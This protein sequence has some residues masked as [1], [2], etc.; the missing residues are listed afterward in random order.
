MPNA[1]IG[2]LRVVLGMNAGEFRR[3]S[4]S[5][6]GEL[7]TLGQ[8]FS[9]I[10]SKIDRASIFVNTGILA[11]RRFANVSK[12][13][14]N[15]ASAFEQ[16]MGNVG[17]L[18]NTNT[19]NL[20][21][22]SEAVLAI[23]R[24]TP[25]S[26]NELTS[27]LYDVR[28]AGIPAADALS[29]L[30]GSAQL[31]VAGLGT[32]KEAVDLVTSSI[33]AFGLRGEDA[34]RVYDQIFKT[35][36]A[37]KT[38][39][40]QLAQGFGAVAGTVAT[41]GIKLDDYLSSVAALTTTGLPA[42]QAHTQIRA[43]IAG[44]LRET[45]ET[46]A[47]FDALGVKTFKQLVEQSGSVVVAFERIVRATRG[48][49]AQMIKL[50]GSVEAY[51]AVIGLAGKQNEAYQS[52]L[53][54]MRDG[55]N[56]VSE[57]FDKQDS[58]VSSTT[59]RLTNNIQALG[60]AMG[61][62]LAPAIKSISD[63]VE[64]LTTTFK[65][66]SPEMQEIIAKTGVF[67]AVV[68]PAVIAIGFFG[69]ALASLLPVFAAVGG[70]VAGL[71]A[72]TGPIGMFII[73]ASLATTAWFTFKDEIISIWESIS[74][75]VSD[76]IDSITAK[77]QQFALSISKAF[78]LITEGEFTA[79][80]QQLGNTFVTT[81]DQVNRAAKS[82][83]LAAQEWKAAAE[84][85]LPAAAA[86]FN[87]GFVLPV[88]EGLSE[89]EKLW[90][91]HNEAAR[92]FGL[93]TIADI[94]SPIEEMIAQQQRLKEALDAG[95]LSAGQFGAAMQKATFVAL[96]AYAGMASGI[97]NNLAMAFGESKA[98]AIAAAVINTAESI[99]KTLATYGATPWGLAAAAAAA[100]AGAAQ[101]ATIRSANK[102]GGGGG[103]SA[104]TSTAAASAGPT[105]IPQS[106]TVNL[107]GD[108]FGREQVFNLINSIN[109][110][111][112]DGAKIRIAA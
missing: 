92:R 45:K 13:I 10:S 1:V 18:I 85:T 70:L 109:D 83:N 59:Q 94:R 111:V 16:G 15:V 44:L 56:A 9:D 76:K 58:T 32:T 75:F 67:V 81:G 102:G 21:A 27:A 99:T 63:F 62:A 41:A 31:A 107:H 74:T 20:N 91:R 39:I 11:A 87:D 35:V 71:V 68:G 19:E 105:S 57:A 34:E 5:V 82:F 108:T 97:A 38:T 14:L 40:S 37:G 64:D 106:V 88:G 104:S 72:A 49:D 29:V 79:A 43:A 101:I 66:L 33:N 42:A 60:I 90:N 17:T 84:T 110:A 36:K 7:A 22:M 73:A 100:A 98:F 4:K 53:K 46:K 61:N 30:E 55:T 12:A 28:S 80:W 48:N 95:G 24:R 96:N 89:L 51:N 25:V 65:S 23:G 112:A 8:K 78:T 47:L 93:Q 6:Q 3:G 54:T 103:S 2:S 77:M 26:L 86:S 52:T 50:L 69:N